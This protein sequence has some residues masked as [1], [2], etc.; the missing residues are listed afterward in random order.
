[1]S[2]TLPE[3]V[4][5]EAGLVTRF[6]DLLRREQAELKSG[7]ASALP[8][9]TQQKSALIDEIN[10][11]AN[12]R[13]LLLAEAGFA[14]DKTGM[15]AWLNEHPGERKTRQTWE[16]MLAAAR[17]IQ[18]LNRLNGRLVSIHLSATQ[19]ALASLTEQARRS[20]LYGPNGQAAPLTGHRI[21][22]SA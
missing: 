2:S 15:T 7:N 18:E 12:Q 1:M 6:A 5:G 16:K 9:L 20:T 17:D 21:I 11:A 8:E 22:D 13:N 19:E 10:A 4:N 14:L 3:V